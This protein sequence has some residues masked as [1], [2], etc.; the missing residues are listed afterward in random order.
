VQNPAEEVNVPPLDGLVLEEEIVR[1]ESDAVCQIGGGPLLGRLNDG[2]EIL[3]DKGE[4][5]K[6]TSNSKAGKPL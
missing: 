5:G 2:F 6:L 1:H 4:G 3:D